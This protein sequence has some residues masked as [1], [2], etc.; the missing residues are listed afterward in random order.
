MS[1]TEVNKLLFSSKV[2]EYQFSFWFDSIFER[3]FGKELYEQIK[4]VLAVLID[5]FE[6]PG[7]GPAKKT[8]VI[9]T[10][11]EFLQALK[12]LP[13][14]L[15]FF[16]RLAIEAI[17]GFLV[18]AVLGYMKKLGWTEQKSTKTVSSLAQ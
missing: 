7:E 12:V 18:E 2:A 5:F 8:L 13:T 17:L 11:I 16:Q 6:Q 4:K 3:I 14:P 15:P 1:N 10:A 9:A